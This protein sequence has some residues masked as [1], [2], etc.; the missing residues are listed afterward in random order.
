M[1]KQLDVRYLLKRVFFLERVIKIFFQDHQWRALHLQEKMTLAEAKISRK[2]FK[3][4]RRI[5]NHPITQN[6]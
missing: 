6:E 4:K 2:E 3:L 5:F 1:V